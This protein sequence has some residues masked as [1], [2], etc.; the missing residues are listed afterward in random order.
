MDVLVRRVLSRIVGSLFIFAPADELCH[1]QSCK[2]GREQRQADWFWNWRRWS[3]CLGLKRQEQPSDKK[4]DE[5]DLYLEKF[6]DPRSCDLPL[7][8][9]DYA[10]TVGGRERHSRFPI[11]PSAGGSVRP[12][13]I[14][15]AQWRA[16]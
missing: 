1:A 3:T 8:C 14:L 9:L 6:H 7:C 10:R 16:T 2:A 11:S 5:Y 13:L 4:S 15:Q 12:R